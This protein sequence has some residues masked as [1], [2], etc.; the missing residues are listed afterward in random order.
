[1]DDA[2]LSA[3]QDILGYKIPA[4]VLMQERREMT[5]LR[6]ILRRQRAKPTTRL[7]KLRAA[8]VPYL[9]TF[10]S[11]LCLQLP[12]VFSDRH[13]KLFYLVMEPGTWPVMFDDLEARKRAT[14][15]WRG[16]IEGLLAEWTSMNVVTG[17]II[18]SAVTFLAAPGLPPVSTYGMLSGI[19]FSLA[20]LTH[21]TYYTQYYRSLL[22]DKYYSLLQLRQFC[23]VYSKMT[24]YLLCLPMLN[25]LLSIL[26]FSIGTIA[27]LWPDP[28]SKA[29]TATEMI[30]PWI[31]KIIIPIVFFFQ[32]GLIPVSYKWNRSA[33]FTTDEL[34]A[35]EEFRRAQ[36]L[37]WEDKMAVDQLEHIRREEGIAQGLPFFST[38]NSEVP[39]TPSSPQLSSQEEQYGGNHKENPAHW[40][41]SQMAL[42]PADAIPLGYEGAA[43]PSVLY[44]ARVY[45]QGRWHFGKAGSH[46][47]G[48]AAIVFENREVPC[49]SYE[50][51]L[52]PPSHFA[53]L[54]LGDKEAFSSCST[55]IPE[56]WVPVSIVQRSGKRIHLAATSLNGGLHLGSVEEG[57]I[58]ADVPY[59]G[60]KTTV[61]TFRVLLTRTGADL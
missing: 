16:Y 5:K 47:M 6:H 36:V 57:C 21:G 38:R 15:A 39:P 48:G 7:Q 23:A 53:W 17:L 4:A 11:V 50:V 49:S 10:M 18:A 35:A 41:P 26:A 9:D 46:L 30:G 61:T 29:P 22:D 27:F 33:F 24:A 58:S 31:A 42:I 12:R 8:L 52:G 54:E 60:H 44:A 28:D 2:T 59:G 1:M 32:L 3:M 43:Y 40:A 45:F 34:L 51:L 55:A 14:I 20:S 13:R 19:C 37:E 25:F 56:G